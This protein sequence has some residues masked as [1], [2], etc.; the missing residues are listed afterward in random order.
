MPTI[1]VGSLSSSAQ[2]SFRSGDGELL[3]RPWDA[4]DAAVLYAAFQDPTIRHWHARQMTSLEESREWIAAAN[5]GWRQEES[6]QWVI[7]RVADGEILGRMSLRGMNLLEGLAHCGYWVL[8]N[9]R[10]AGVAPRA[11]AAMADWALEAAGFHRLELGHSVGNEASCR[12]AAKSG[13]VLEG[14]RRSSALHTDGWHDMHLHA[15][16][17]DD[18]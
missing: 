6:A 2:P 8:P 7:A 15:R 14:T 11:L 3:L 4:A 10:G 18:A 5:R 16:I 13:F 12:V 1:P 17:Q 9:A